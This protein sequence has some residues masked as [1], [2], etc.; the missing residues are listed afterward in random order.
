MDANETTIQILSKIHEAIAET[1]ARLDRQE[2]A[3]EGLGKAMVQAIAEAT[4]RLDRQEAAIVGTGKAMVAA[5]VETNARLDTV[6]AATTELTHETRAL[7]SRIDN[8]LIGPVARQV[9]ELDE[10]VG[11]LE[12]RAGIAR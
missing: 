6:V 5:V 9:R 11:R 12:A 10:R 4:V 3:I 2:A 7:G 8:V 1:N